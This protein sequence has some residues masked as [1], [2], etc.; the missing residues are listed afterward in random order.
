MS[1]KSRFQPRNPLKEQKTVPPRPMSEIQNSY[2]QLAYKAGELQYQLHIWK[3]ELSKVNEAM[4]AVNQEAAARQQLDAAAKK[5][6]EEAAQST[7]LEG[8]SNEQQN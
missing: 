4:V 2:S 8:V 6:S 1:G 7:P 3:L 5:E